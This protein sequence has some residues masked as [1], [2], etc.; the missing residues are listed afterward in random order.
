MEAKHVV[1]DTKSNVV[2]INDYLLCR[3]ASLAIHNAR[4]EKIAQRSS[5]I[6]D[7]FLGRLAY[8]FYAEVINPLFGYSFGLLF[9]RTICSL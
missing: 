5:F 7:R 1:N 4:V 2:D 9:A 6:S 8:N 3:P